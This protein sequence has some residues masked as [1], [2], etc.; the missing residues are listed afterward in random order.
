MLSFDDMLSC[1]V[2]YIVIF[3][4]TI[5]YNDRLSKFSIDG[6]EKDGL[7]ISHMLALFFLKVSFLTLAK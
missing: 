2:P 6:G 7:T 4:I 5:S 3:R 1:V